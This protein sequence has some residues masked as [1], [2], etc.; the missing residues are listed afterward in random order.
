MFEIHVGPESTIKL[1]GRLDAAQAD[2]AL[3]IFKTL[4]HS[5]T[6]DCA[7]LD[8]ISSAGISVILETHKRL[9]AAGHT[10]RLVQMNA[11]VRTVFAYTGLDKVLD[12]Q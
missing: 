9:H 5:V 8:Y 10:L 4:T 2:R 7:A 11:R 3:A 12:I 1:V 6:A